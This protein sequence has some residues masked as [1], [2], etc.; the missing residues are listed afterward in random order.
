[1]IFERMLKEERRRAFLERKEAS[2]NT[3]PQELEALK[4]YI[5]S[6][7]CTA[8]IRRLAAGEFFFSVPTVIRLRKRASDKR[9]TVYR[10]AENE[11]MLMK[12]MAFL[13][14]DYDGLFSDNLYSFRLGK[15]IGGIFRR[16]SEAHLAQ[17]NWVLKGD[18]RGFG[19]HVDPAI[20][21]EKL[22]GIFSDDPSFLL[23][24]RRL[25]LR[26][27]YYDGGSLTCGSTGA[28][29]GCALCNFFEN[30]Y[31]LDL[32]DRIAEKAVYYCRFSDDIAVFLPTREEAEA[33]REWLSAVYAARGLSFNTEKTR[34]I[35]PGEPFDLLGFSITGQ[36]YDIA[37]S[38]MEKIEWKLRHRAKRLVK[39]QC[40]GRL[41]KEEAMARMI[42]S[43]DAQ[44]FGCGGEEDPHALK[45]TEWAFSVLT[46]I[47]SLK[48]LDACAQSCIRY[49]GSGGR[50]TD[51]KYRVRYKAM[52]RMGYRTLVHAFYHRE[53]RNE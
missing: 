10:F 30:V 4:A 33:C 7:A 39:M 36:V 1:M 9:R 14:H 22:E 28:L 42:R 35:P 5:L 16:I 46:G 38:S 40:A 43:I 24:L 41:S 34:I 27:R 48:R 12:Y 32:D 19:E 2:Y 8:D 15:H 26:G 17:D 3:S 29:S 11:R 6:D 25:L 37:E 50:N 45:W 23:F 13:L 53:D 44:F 21:Y 20:L 31:L 47:D 52:R 49:V 51:A 18:I